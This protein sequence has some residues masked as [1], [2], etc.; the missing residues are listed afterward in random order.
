LL[1]NPR[2]DI[3]TYSK[4]AK[5]KKMSRADVSVLPRVVIGRATRLL[6]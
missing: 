2:S 3:A 6:S 5:G 1:L 4:S